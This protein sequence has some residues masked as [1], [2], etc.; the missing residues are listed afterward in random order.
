MGLL[1]FFLVVV[2]L[3]VCVCGLCFG[4]DIYDERISEIGWSVLDIILAIVFF[5]TT[6]IL[7]VL[8]VGM[9]VYDAITGNEQYSK[10]MIWLNEPIRERKRRKK[11]DGD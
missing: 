5:P 10:T 8:V 3:I 2:Y 7:C 4:A 9:N 1:T 11:H 6:I